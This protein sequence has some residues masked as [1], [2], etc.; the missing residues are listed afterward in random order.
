MPDTD[1]TA[2][3]VIHG[4]HQG[5]WFWERVTPLLDR[6]SLAVDLPG[7]GRH[8]ADLS[9]VGIEQTVASVVADIDEAGFDRVILAGNSI[10]SATIP[11]VAS[12]L[13]ERVAH[14]VFL[15]TPIA[16]EGRTLMESFPAEVQSVASQRIRTDG[17]T[18]NTS[19]DDRRFMSCNDM[20]DEQA[21][22]VLNRAVPDSLRLFHEPVSWAGTEGIPRTYVRLLKDQ[23]LVLSTQEHMIGNLRRSGGPVRVVDLDAGHCPMISDPAGTAAVL[24]EVAGSSSRAGR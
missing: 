12:R 10:A 14:L 18:M 15:G 5:S 8:P 7:R 23:A 6:P 9:T 11:G 3:V 16:L 13:R 22:F 1:R 20:D 4:G 19:D 24:D 17:S 2:F 21:N